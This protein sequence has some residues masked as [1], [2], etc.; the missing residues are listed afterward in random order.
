MN[1]KLLVTGAGGFVAGN[2]LAEALCLLADWEIEALSRSPAPTGWQESGAPNPHL[3]WRSLD[4]L[5]NTRL[6]ETLNTFRP[7]AII[8]AAAIA[9]IDYCETHRD[10]ARSVNVELT[11]R[12]AAAAKLFGSKLVFVS[13]DTVF[14]GE[15]GGY[16]ESDTPRAVN[17]YA[18][19]KIEAEGVVRDSGAQWVIARTSLVMGWPRGGIGN[20]FLVRLEN[21]LAEGKDVSVPAE[22]IRTPIDVISLAHALIELSTE[23]FEGVFHLAGPEAVDRLTLTK[24]LAEKMG[25][26]PALVLSQESSAM[27][28]RAPRPRDVSLDSAKARTMLE[29]LLNG[30]GSF[31]P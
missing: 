30:F 28:G 17:H 1:R 7:D 4:V 22:E 15:R 23:P 10:E 24:S 19:T 8:H 20:S 18:Q 21:S 6:L 14:D 5:D 3:H 13:T 2:V 26:D 31:Q 16:N 9:D 12:V 27:V 25:Y 29:T 11:R